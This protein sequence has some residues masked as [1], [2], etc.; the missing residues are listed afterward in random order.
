MLLLAAAFP[1]IFLS[2]DFSFLNETARYM[3]AIVMII[4]IH[5]LDIAYIVN[6]SKITLKKMKKGFVHTLVSIM[7]MAISLL[8][9]GSIDSYNAKLF[10]FIL[11][12]TALFA[13][14]ILCIQMVRKTTTLA[15]VQVK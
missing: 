14:K 13:C 15:K 3:F 7:L 1:S 10:W 12:W 8:F 5:L 2:L 6:S 4:V 11:F 9:V